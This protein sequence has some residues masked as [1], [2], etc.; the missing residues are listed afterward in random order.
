MDSERTQRRRDAGLQYRRDAETVQISAGMAAGVDSAAVSLD[1]TVG[2]PNLVA[3]VTQALGIA[4]STIGNVAGS[5][6]EL[7]NGTVT[8]WTLL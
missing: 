4:R 5:V 3:S 8:P 2:G 1:G 6:S 7:T